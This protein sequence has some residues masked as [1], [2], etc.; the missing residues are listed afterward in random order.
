[1]KKEC[2]RYKKKHTK[3]EQQTEITLKMT[4]KLLLLLVRLETIKSKSSPNEFSYISRRPM[5]VIH[6]S[7]SGFTE[8]SARE[9]KYAWDSVKHT[10][11]QND[12]VFTW[13]I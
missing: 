1:M 13:Y 6:T 2:K 12:T 9:W 10:F 5:H 7:L 11:A 8:E 4:E 3:K